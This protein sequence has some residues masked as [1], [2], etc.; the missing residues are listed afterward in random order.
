M[1]EKHSG[2][3]LPVFLPN[4]VYI[5]FPIINLAYG[6]AG[7]FVAVLYYIPSLV[8]TYTLG[9]FVAA[10]KS[11]VENFKEVLKVPTMYAAFLGLAFNLLH[12]DVPPLVIRPLSFIGGMVT[13]A[14]VLT[15]GYSLSRI[16]LSSLPTTFL[17]SLIRMGGGLALGF[18]TVYLFDLT[19]IYRSIVIFMSAMPAAVV[20]YMLA[21]MYKNEEEMVASVVLVTTIASLFVIPVLLRIL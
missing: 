13:P 9:I 20:T 18:L 5:P 16:K 11:K 10:G 1:K 14:M 8:I 6:A 2:L 7:I 17:T 3:Y 4:T 15:L 21:A 19:G 12:V